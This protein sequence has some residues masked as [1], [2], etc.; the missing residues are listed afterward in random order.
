MGRRADG[1]PKHGGWEAPAQVA[2][3][4]RTSA[5]PDCT[6]VW[7]GR[8]ELEPDRAEEEAS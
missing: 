8:T 5:G 3:H 2:E 4:P 1:S 6:K 7:S